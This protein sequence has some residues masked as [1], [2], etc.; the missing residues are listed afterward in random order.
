[1]HY[2]DDRR[3]SGRSGGWLSVWGEGD[4]FPLGTEAAPHRSDHIAARLHDQTPNRKKVKKRRRGEG[5]WGEHR[6][7]RGRGRGHGVT[8]KW[9]HTG[10]VVA[11]RKR[12]RRRATNLRRGF[13]DFPSSM[14]S[15]CRVWRS[16]P[17]CVGDPTKRTLSLA[18]KEAMARSTKT[19]SC[20]VSRVFLLWLFSRHPSFRLTAGSQPQRSLCRA[21]PLL[22]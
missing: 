3:R 18:Y 17:I 11:F 21:Q 14:P 19:M 5:G 7:E 2:C 4:I 10:W 13:S 1:M 20:S 9:K 12:D 15:L 8:E 16:I 22:D 6:R